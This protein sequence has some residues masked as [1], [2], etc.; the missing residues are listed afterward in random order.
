M[1]RMSLIVFEK[2]GHILGAFTRAANPDGAVTAAQVVGEALTVRHAENGSELFH[3]SASLLTV[4]TIDRVD[5]VITSHRNYVL[6]D[7]LAMEK[8]DPVTAP[9]YDSANKKL[10]VKLDAN[11]TEKLVAYA[12]VET[13]GEPPKVIPIEI[14]ALDD[15]GHAPVTLT[16][17]TIYQLLVLIPGYRA[18]FKSFT[19]A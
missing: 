18:Q 19:A 13:E 4:K 8:G 2:T 9:G 3:V 14:P 15:E 11:A 5:D 7:G 16:P 12:Q 6:K 1:T 17:G 10:D